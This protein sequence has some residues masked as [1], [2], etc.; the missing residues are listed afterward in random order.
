MSPTSFRHKLQAKLKEAEES[1]E[2]AQSKYSSL[3]KTKNHIAS[4]LED[5]NLDLE[6]VGGYGMRMKTCVYIYRTCACVSQK[7]SM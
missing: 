6:K 5:L 7:W 2:A 4:E 1:L 3:E